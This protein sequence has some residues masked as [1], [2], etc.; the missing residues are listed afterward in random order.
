[1]AKHIGDI[2]GYERGNNIREALSSHSTFKCNALAKEVA[3]DFNEFV[4]ERNWNNI[5]LQI[6]P[7]KVDVIGK[8]H[9][10]IILEMGIEV[11]DEGKSATEIMN[12]I[13]DIEDL[14]DAAVHEIEDFDS[15]CISLK[16]DN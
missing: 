13:S 14:I 9:E 15:I 3:V 2:F 11:L 6:N 5:R 1:M 7:L 10:I 8:D 16:M 4:K 12:A